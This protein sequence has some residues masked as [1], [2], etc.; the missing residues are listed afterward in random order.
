MLRKDKQKQLND[1]CE[2]LQ[3]ANAKGDMRKLFQQVRSLTSTLK[4][5]L[6]CV[7]LAEGEIISETDKIAERWREYCK[8]L[9][10]DKD[11]QLNVTD[12]HYVRAPPPLKAEIARAIQQTASRKSPGPDEV[13]VEL[14]KKGGE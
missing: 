10:E 3:K 7:E 1:M 9:Y 6:H 8:D 12:G 14:L 11:S 4:P 5:K 13:P 2:E